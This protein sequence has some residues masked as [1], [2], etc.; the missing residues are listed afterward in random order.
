M[1]K[2]L[3]L[4]FF[5]ISIS[6]PSKAEFFKFGKLKIELFERDKLIK[7]RGS[8]D[9]GFGIAKINVFAEKNNDNKINSIITTVKYKGEKFGTEMRTWWTDYFFKSKNGLFHN[10]KESNL[11]LSNEGFNN[12][13]VVQELNLNDYLNQHDDFKEYKRIIKKL[14]KNIT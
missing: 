13:I 11:I 8:I 6:S 2:I 7:T 10:D 4:I 3:S 12:G 14:K 9:E 1:K 5:L